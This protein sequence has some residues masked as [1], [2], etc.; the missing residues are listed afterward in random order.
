MSDVLM[1]FQK[2]F[3][4]VMLISVV[5][6]VHEWGHFIVA[7]LCGVR[8]EA[9]SLFFGKP[10]YKKKRGDTE[11]RIGTIP[12]GG[13]VKMVG[14]ADGKHENY[15]EMT[16]EEKSVSFA[17]KPLAQRAAIVAAGPAMNFVLAFVIFSIMFMVGYPTTTTLIGDVTRDGAAWEAGLRPGD[18]VTAIDGDKVW[19]W[20]DMASIVE[21]NPE[22]AMDFTVQRGDETR[23]VTV[24]PRLG[25]KKNIFQFEENAGL[26]GVS[27]DGFRPIAGVTGPQTAAAQAGLKTGDL[28]KSIDGKPVHAFADVERELLASPGPHKVTVERG[29][30]ARREA[31]RQPTDVEL[32]LPA[33]PGAT[34][35]Q[36]YG[37]ERADLY[38]LEVVEGSPAEKAGLRAGDRFVTLNGEAPS[39][40]EEFSGIVRQHPG[41][42]LSVVVRRDGETRTIGV[43]PEAAQEKDLLGE[44][45]EVGR[46]GVYPWISY[47]NPEMVNE[48]HLN[49]FVAVWRGVELTGYWTVMTLKGFVYL[50]T[51]DVSVK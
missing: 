46:L 17:H 28:F 44:T 34:G 12:F 40:W 33:L 49:P 48:R 32:T 51:G 20:D 18:R 14:Q 31:D 19:R 45:V 26:I 21:E 36:D 15:D 41:E 13:Y 22:K 35:I 5:V 37:L 8:V 11:W 39:G 24:T 25:L 29:G 16:D 50:F 27:P 9:F 1:I 47:S 38:V 3:F 43:T 6:I 30:L 2:L 42:E 4:F 7:R 10:L 23:H